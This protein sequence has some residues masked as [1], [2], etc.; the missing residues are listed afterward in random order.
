MTEALH[1][2]ERAEASGR[3]REGSHKGGDREEGRELEARRGTKV[4]ALWPCE[5]PGKRR[6]EPRAG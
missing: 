5:C 1:A 2:E 4:T 6:K 3:T